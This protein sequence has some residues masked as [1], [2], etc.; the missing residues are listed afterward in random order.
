MG[1]VDEIRELF[2]SPENS[3]AKQGS[4]EDF[5]DKKPH[6]LNRAQAFRKAAIETPKRDSF[7]PDVSPLS[8]CGSLSPNV[9]GVFASFDPLKS[10]DLNI[11]GSS[12]S[13]TPDLIQDWNINH[14]NS[15]SSVLDGKNKFPGYRN[16]SAATYSVGKSPFRHSSS[17]ASKPAVP[18]RPITV[19]GN[20]VRQH[21]SQPVVTLN[22][23]YSNTSLTNSIP[24]V[25]AQS[26]DPFSDLHE[27]SV[28]NRKSQELAQSKWEKFE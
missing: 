17:P 5:D 14:L 2:S 10:G 1:R 15:G 25:K 21:T 11:S 27:I 8:S 22:P 18:D 4:S 6:Q 9:S 20:T 26:S 28:T 7:K 12:D 19:F 13:S 23:S 3:P 24:D 16:P